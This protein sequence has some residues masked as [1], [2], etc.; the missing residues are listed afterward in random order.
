M[1]KHLVIFDYHVVTV[2]YLDLNEMY[3]VEK[4]IVVEEYVENLQVD[5]V[6]IIFFFKLINKKSKTNK[7]KQNKTNN[8]YYH[9][10][11]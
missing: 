3:L 1:L 11:S 4:L 10:H 6:P 7:T 8:Y 2:M 5:L 9:Y